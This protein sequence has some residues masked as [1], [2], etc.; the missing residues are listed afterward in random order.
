MKPLSQGSQLEHRQLAVDL[1][2]IVEHLSTALIGAV[3][4]EN[5]G[6]EVV[7]FGDPL[8]MILP[9]APLGQ[10]EKKGSLVLTGFRD[11]KC[12]I[13]LLWIVHQWPHR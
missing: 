3:I 9:L 2:R 4:G 6:F 7:R 1:G 5:I 12:R 11:E 8:T 10:Q 13:P